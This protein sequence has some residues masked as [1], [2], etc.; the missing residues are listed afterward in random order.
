MKNKRCRVC[1]GRGSHYWDCPKAYKNKDENHRAK[2]RDR[3][4][5]SSPDL[6]FFYQN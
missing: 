3:N 6:M 1:N 5:Y 2:H 4:K